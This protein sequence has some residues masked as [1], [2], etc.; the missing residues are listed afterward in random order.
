MR[1]PIFFAQ[2]AEELLE[3]ARFHERLGWGLAILS[4]VILI[5]GIAYTLLK[6]K[7]N[8]DEPTKQ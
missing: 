2:T 4:V 1:L 3:K 8:D 5:C 7:K 6:K